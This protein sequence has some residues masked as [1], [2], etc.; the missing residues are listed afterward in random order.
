MELTNEQRMILNEVWFELKDKIINFAIATRSKDVTVISSLN[1]IKN[2]T[3][4]LY[5]N[6]KGQEFNIILE[7]VTFVIDTI[8]TTKSIAK[9]KE[10]VDA[11]YNFSSL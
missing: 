4:K 7:F 6:Y 10:K 3:L 9:T 11:V 5:S 8:I 1:N 2:D